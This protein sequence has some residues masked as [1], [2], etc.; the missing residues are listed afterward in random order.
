[1]PV[2]Y[3]YFTAITKF[4]KLLKFNILSTASNIHWILHWLWCRQ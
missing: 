3:G 4:K 1:M 2:L